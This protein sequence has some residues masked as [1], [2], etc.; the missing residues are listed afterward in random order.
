M[1]KRLLSF[2]RGIGELVLPLVLV[3]AP[4]RTRLVRILWR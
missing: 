2:S 1:E 4:L 3:G